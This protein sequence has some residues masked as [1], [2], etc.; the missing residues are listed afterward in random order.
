MP[1][2]DRYKNRIVNIEFDFMEKLDMLPYQERYTIVFITNGSATGILNERLVNITAPCIL[3]ISKDDI[4]KITKKDN[5]SAQS[6]RFDSDFLKSTRVSDRKD[7]FSA[8]LRI[9][10]GL[11]LFKRDSVHTGICGITDNAYPQLFEWFFVLG[12]EVFAQSNELWACRIKK[13][14]IQ[15]LSL[16]EKLSRQKEPSP[17]DVVLDYIHTNYTNKIILEDFIRCSNLN[18]VSLNAMF[19]EKFGFTAMGYLQRYRLQIAGELLVHTDMSLN[20]IARSTGF[21]YDTYFIKQFTLKRGITPTNYR[22]ICR[23]QAT[24]Y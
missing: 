10:T 17:V 3:C 8:K 13:Y 19:K 16:L 9:E 11:S 23:E 5:I 2:F 7:S 6:F 18:R 22:N 1:M 12:A 4:I 21:E 20:E 15:F 14:L 24:T